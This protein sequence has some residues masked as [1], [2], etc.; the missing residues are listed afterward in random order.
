MGRKKKKGKTASSRDFTQKLVYHNFKVLQVLFSGNFYTAW[1]SPGA[2]PH[3]IGEPE[4]PAYTGALG[5]KFLGP[6]SS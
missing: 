5:R 3:D 4:W 2:A 6:T 1:E